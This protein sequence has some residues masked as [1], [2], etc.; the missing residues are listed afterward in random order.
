[1]FYNKK[2]LIFINYFSTALSI[3][4]LFGKLVFSLNEFEINGLDSIRKLKEKA[5][6]KLGIETNLIEFIEKSTSE[7]LDDNMRI[8][9][10]NKNDEMT[11]FYVSNEPGGEKGGEIL[12]PI[13]KIEVYITYNIHKSSCK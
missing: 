2:V 8:E 1:L 6:Q 9:I 11:V 12:Y 13:R 4:D 10:N 3:C 7:K 5:S